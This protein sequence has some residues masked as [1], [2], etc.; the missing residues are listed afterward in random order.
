MS[1]FPRKDILG[2]TIVITAA[3][4]AFMTTG[5]A[6]AA[7][8]TP[9]AQTAPAAHAVSATPAAP[10]Q[11]LAAL[12]WPLVVQGPEESALSP[13]STC[14]TSE[15]ARASQSTGY[16]GRQLSQR[17]GASKRGSGLASTVSLDRSRGTHKPRQ[18]GAPWIRASP[19]RGHVAA[20]HAPLAT[21][22]PAS[23]LAEG[24][25][26]REDARSIPLSSIRTLENLIEFGSQV[27]ADDDSIH[28]TPSH[29]SHY[30]PSST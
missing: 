14:S 23:E 2:V 13:S 30:R 18:P 21:C 12:S 20:L 8:A 26:R 27:G 9:T 29:A 17:S 7:T 4:T 16:S 24:A 25:V 5:L 10:E 15:S 6:S 1:N 28:A 22:P 19:R 11:L 3:T